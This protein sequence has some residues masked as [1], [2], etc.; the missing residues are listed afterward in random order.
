MNVAERADHAFVQSHLAGRTFKGAARR[1]FDVAGFTDGRLQP[2]LELLGHRDLDLGV[3][4][5]RPEDAHPF[6]PPFWTN[7]RELLLAGELAGLRE[8]RGFS[9][10]MA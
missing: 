8:I 7:D 6:D 2:K 5:R 1:T 4:T 10:L 3:F 9:E